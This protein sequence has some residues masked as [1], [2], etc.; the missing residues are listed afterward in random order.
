MRMKALQA[1]GDVAKSGALAQSQAAA[2]ADIFSAQLA[3]QRRQA[4][5]DRLERTTQRYHGQGQKYGRQAG[6]TAYQ[7]VQ[8]AGPAMGGGD[9][10]A[11]GAALGKMS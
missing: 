10:A 9:A 4:I 3:E 2:Q 7:A 11:A 8:L 6:E 5:L 1:Q